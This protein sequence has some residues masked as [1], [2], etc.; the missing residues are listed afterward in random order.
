MFYLGCL[1]LLVSLF[2]VFVS[3][4]LSIFEQKR[5]GLMLY[6]LQEA[7]FFGFVDG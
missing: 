4:E 7:I 5:A 3:V 6:R 1:P 2:P